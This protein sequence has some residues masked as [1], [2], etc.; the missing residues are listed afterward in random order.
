VQNLVFLSGGQILAS[1]SHDQTIRLWDVASGRLGRTLRGHQQGLFALA[2]LPN[3]KTLVSSARDGTVRMW[4]ARGSGP[5]PYGMINATVLRWNFAP[6]S[7]SIITV[8]ATGKV[9][10]W[11]GRGFRELEELADVG[12]VANSYAG[13]GKLIGWP[14]YACLAAD[15]PLV[16]ITKPNDVVQVW[17]WNNKTMEHEITTTGGPIL[18]AST[19]AFRAGGRKLLMNWVSADGKSRGLEE[20]DLAAGKR[21]RTWPYAHKGTWAYSTV[22]ADHRW[23]LFGWGE[24]PFA[25]RRNE[26]PVSLIDL[27]TGRERQLPGVGLWWWDNVSFSPDGQLLAIPGGPAST[28]WQLQPFRLHKSLPAG[29]TAAFSPDGRRLA[30]GGGPLWDTTSWEPVLV[31]EV[32][33]GNFFGS[34]FSPDGN[35]F[36]AWTQ[37]NELH[38]WSAPSWVEIEEAEKARDQP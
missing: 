32:S 26:N 4:D 30:F 33:R 3:D 21:T 13:S 28:L 5:N 2:S 6:D 16:A 25:G 27:E 20:W 15:V 7:R 38:L 10:R 19:V 9:R 22:T 17:N 29:S 36:A 1:G 24:N 11:H 18:A 8:D 14:M 34:A 37:F 31:L 35:V 23:G 12:P